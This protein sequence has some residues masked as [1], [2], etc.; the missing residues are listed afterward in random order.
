MWGVFHPAHQLRSEY[1]NGKFASG[2]WVR[3]WNDELFSLSLSLSVLCC[4]CAEPAGESEPAP[5]P[6][7]LGE[8]R[9]VSGLHP[10]RAPHAGAV[11]ARNQGGQHRRTEWVQEVVMWGLKQ[12]K[13][14]RHARTYYSWGRNTSARLTYSFQ[15]TQGYTRL[16]ILS[17]FFLFLHSLT[18]KYKKNKAEFYKLTQRSSCRYLVYD[19]DQ[20][21]TPRFTL[22]YGCVKGRRCRS[23][24]LEPVFGLSVLGYRR[25]KDTTISRWFYTNELMIVNI[26]SNFCP[27]IPVNPS[28]WT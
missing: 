17:C 12:P 13:L 9:R 27:L 18:K 10:G 20:L 26:L 23:R 16:N 7:A 21:S 4:R 14:T 22:P 2:I 6:A 19:W 1:F 5:G 11:A 3:R 25:N 28:H 8:G 15:H 24:S